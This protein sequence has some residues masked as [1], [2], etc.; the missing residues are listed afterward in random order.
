[1]YIETLFQRNV[2]WGARGTG[3][4]ELSVSKIKYLFKIS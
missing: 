4:A 3:R 1:M 2:C